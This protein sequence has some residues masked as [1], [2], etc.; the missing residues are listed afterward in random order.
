MGKAYI[1][2][3]IDPLFIL[4]GKFIGEAAILSVLSNLSGISKV[5]EGKFSEA[6]L[7]LIGVAVSQ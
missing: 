5:E 3:S 1:V 4:E 7:Y 6:I 2:L